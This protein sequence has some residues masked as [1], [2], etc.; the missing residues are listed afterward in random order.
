MGEAVAQIREVAHYLQTLVVQSDTL[1][2][3]YKLESDRGQE[4]ASL[5]RKIKV[6]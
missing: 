6:L 4:L 5:L 1:S 3:K 2:V